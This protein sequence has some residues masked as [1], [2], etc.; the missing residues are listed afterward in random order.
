[1]VLNTLFNGW[2]YRHNRPIIIATSV[3]F[4]R[5]SEPEVG[6][7]ENADKGIEF[8]KSILNRSINVQ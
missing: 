7:L 2:I 4:K 3:L 6:A 5:L 1:M 8:T